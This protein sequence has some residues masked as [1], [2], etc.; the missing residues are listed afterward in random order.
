VCKRFFQQKQQAK[1]MPH[2]IDTPPPPSHARRTQIRYNE[3]SPLFDVGL[4]YAGARDARC[5]DD[6]TESLINFGGLRVP[7]AVNEIVW[8]CITIQHSTH[9]HTHTHTH[10][11]KSAARAPS[12]QRPAAS[13]AHTYTHTRTACCMHAATVPCACWLV[14]VC[15]RQETNNDVVQTS[16]FFGGCVCCVRCTPTKSTKEAAG[17]DEQIQTNHHMCAI[18]IKVVRCDHAVFALRDACALW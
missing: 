3:P 2:I 17:Q 16:V 7:L 18:K 10:K 1:T 6:Q 9:T 15:A 8:L 4:C 12:R 5:C 13:S 11:L 14:R